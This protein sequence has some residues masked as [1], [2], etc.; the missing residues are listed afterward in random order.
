MTPIEKL[1]RTVLKILNIRDFKLFGCLIYNFQIDILKNII[2]DNVL[3]VNK[4]KNK[5][6]K[7]LTAYTFVQDG[8][9]HI[10]I[11]E[12]F[13]NEHSIEE[14]E[15]ILLH[16][17]LHII[18]GDTYRCKTRNHILFNLA[19]DH[20]INTT[21][22]S[23]VDNDEIPAAI[24]S[25]AF[26]I[27]E[28]EHKDLTKEEVYEYL[29]ENASIYNVGLIDNNNA[30]EVEIGDQSELVISDIKSS[31]DQEEDKNTSDTLK[32]EA[33][34][35][36]NI[37]NKE[38]GE[39][40]GKLKDLIN[41][42]IEIKI[43]WTD[44]IQQAITTV[45]VPSTDSRSWSNIRKRFYVHGIYLPGNDT[46]L[47]P[48]FLIIGV[49]TSGSINQDDLKKFGSIILQSSNHFDLVRIIKHD[50][51]IHED[52]TI[53]AEELKISDIYY[54]FIGRGGTSHKYIFNRIEKSYKKN[55]DISMVILLTDFESNIESIWKNYEWV[56]NV[57][58]KIVLSNNQQPV[59]SYVDSKPIYIKDQ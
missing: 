37:I 35:V 41:K 4:N 19:A 51:D 57:P 6:E 42:I 44:I 34:A 14:L 27:K 24:P 31:S 18:D 15:F 17:I 56:K 55:D 28:L 16:E 2:Y 36:Q 7:V 43:P 22:K 12:N 10:N 33:R 52:K 48:G 49:D 21:L 45:V 53:T 3:E 50:I 58:L 29:L 38:R 40:S 23:A 9:P 30:S 5:I 20:V 26:I 1:R 59:P 54:K 32:A 46:E 8:K 39:S 13:I 47:K 11:Y 25:S